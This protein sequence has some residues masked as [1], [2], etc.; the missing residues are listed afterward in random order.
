MTKNVDNR[1]IRVFI[2]STFQDMKLERDYLL[3]KVFPKLQFEAKKRDVTVTPI[4]LRWGITEE[5]SKSGKVI[6]ICLQE[7]DNS[8]PFFIG[9]VGSRYGWCPPLKELEKNENLKERWGKWLEE[10]LKNGLSVTEI[11][12]QFGALRS[13]I[14]TYAF[15]YIKEDIVTNKED[16]DKVKKFKEKILRNGRFPVIQYDTIENMGMHIEYSIL[17][18]INEL[19]PEEEL[20]DL[21]KERIPH[22]SL[23]RNL[24][25]VYIPNI[26]YFNKLDELLLNS[27]Q[28]G[29]VITGESGI[30]KS[31]LV[32]SWI[33]KHEE[34]EDQNIIYHFIQAGNIL[35][36][37]NAI[38]DRLTN[39]IKYWY[40]L[41]ENDNQKARESDDYFEECLNK[42]AGKHPLIIVI[43]G[44]N[45]ISNTDDA[46]SLNWLPYPPRNVKYL[47]STKRDDITMDILEQRGFAVLNMDV[48]NTKQQT[49]LVQDYL[50]RYGKKLTPKQVNK[51]TGY[52]ICTNAFVLKT[53]LE[54][55]VNNGVHEQLDNQID[56]LMQSATPVDFCENIL[57]NHEILF[58]E[59]FV[60][61]ILGL[62][63]FSKDGLSENEIIKMAHINNQ[64]CWSQ[65]YCFFR[66]HLLIR[67]GR[68]VFSHQYIYDA[69][70]IRY[71]K[72]ER[73]I[74][75]IIVS[76]LNNNL[77][78]YQSISEL[79]F[80]LYKLKDSDCL[81]SILMSPNIFLY[82]IE[83]D[84][85]DLI[86]YCKYLE[87]IDYEKYSFYA[88]Y[89]NFCEEELD[90][91]EIN[92]RI[93]SNFKIAFFL[94]DALEDFNTAIGFFTTLLEDIRY[95]NDYGDTLA[96]VFLH[97][98][99]CFLEIS[100][101]EEAEESLMLCIQTNNNGD[102]SVNEIISADSYRY[103]GHIRCQLGDFEKAIEYV[104]KSITIYDKLYT[105]NN[106][107]SAMGYN[108]IGSFLNYQGDFE[109]AFI[110][111]FKALQ[112]KEY[113]FD[114]LNP[115]LIAVCNNIGYSLVCMNK[116]TEALNYLKRAQKISEINYSHDSLTLANIFSNMGGAYE[117][118]GYY[119]RALY[120][121][122][123]CLKI[124]KK[125]LPEDH[126]NIAASNY[127]IGKLLFLS[128]KNDMA[129]VFLNT[130]LEIYRNK[131]NI[132]DARVVTVKKLICEIENAI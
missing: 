73:T 54:E 126:L 87:S 12:M 57:K 37:H 118:L 63:A 124:E 80:Q 78:S 51:I 38:V 9:L 106:E 62:I 119:D 92:I 120:Y 85:Y 112:I 61:Q 14:D 132:E 49:K 3:N 21:Q 122:T 94:R 30:G 36:N 97:L 75:N 76:Y 121:F 104:K 13:K 47:L 52:K 69:I 17:Q 84:K 34:D 40:C 102:H 59:H 42:I 15:F 27:D 98:G 41:A 81:Y 29:V 129:L 46:K 86:Q 19:F 11:E 68:I 45:Q 88:L 64:F 109:E 20:T 65:F 5:E 60:Q 39:E 67:G 130:S 108:D 100:H 74:R 114:A 79:T 95:F 35:G 99:I 24:T 33:L 89:V 8:R 56:F 7:I 82:L 66:K 110:Y 28:T 128:K 16:V 53:L 90:T 26:D 131:I 77:Q 32:A 72:V 55:L 105:E 25:E 6:E 31:A 93:N 103:L 50:G 48:L 44:I 113:L 117:G 91:E 125:M 58:G 111:L 123:N 18:L 4:D 83:N 43:D 71:K 127:N 1:Q 22:L 70:T 107:H 10:D 101:L 2:S 96:Q 23:I 115:A 116:N